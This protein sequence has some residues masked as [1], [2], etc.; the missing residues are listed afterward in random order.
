MGWLHLPGKPPSS[1]SSHSPSSEWERK[2]RKKKKKKRSR[3][4][5]SNHLPP[6]D[7]CQAS[8]QAATLIKK[9]PQFLLLSMTSISV[10]YCFGQFGSA[11]LI[12]SLPKLLLTPSLLGV[13]YETEEVL[14]LYKHCSAI[15]KSVVSYEHCFGHQQKTQQPMGCYEES[16]LHPSQTQYDNLDQLMA[17]HSLL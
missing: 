12:V 11:V 13:E 3:G 14:K 17:S 9:S 6:A 8:C 10:E 15:A 16:Y 7:W 4:H 2:W 5:K 1:C